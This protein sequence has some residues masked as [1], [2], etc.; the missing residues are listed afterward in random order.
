MNFSKYSGY[1]I[2]AGVALI[3]TIALFSPIEKWLNKKPSFAAIDQAFG[4]YIE[5]YTGGIIFSKSKI[6]IKL[7][8]PVADSSMIGKKIEKNLFSF[9]PNIEGSAYWIDENTIEFRPT[10]MLENEK[11]YK[12]A[13][14]LSDVCPVAEKKFSK[15]EFGFMVI[16]LDFDVKF[17]GLKTNN[18]DSYNLSGKL[19]STDFIE[20]EKIEKVLSVDKNTVKWNH[21]NNEHHF[22]ISDIKRNNEKQS[23]EIK[24]NGD[25]IDIDQEGKQIFNI[26]AKNSFEV[27]TII[28]KYTEQNSIHILFSDPL[29]KQQNLIGLIKLDN[30]DVKNYGI[31]DNELIIY[32]Q[33]NIEGS[34]KLF[35]NTGILNTKGNRFENNFETEIFFQS[36]LPEI[37]SEKNGLIF[38]E[39]SD[40]FLYAFQTIGL[41]SVNLIVF[42]I[43]KENVG[44]YFQSNSYQGSEDLKRFGKPKVFRTIDLRSIGLLQKNQWTRFAIDLKEITDIQKGNLYRIVVQF[45]HENIFKPCDENKNQLLSFFKSD[46]KQIL[47]DQFSDPNSNW[48]YLGNTRKYLGNYNWEEKDNPCNDAYYNQHSYF[49]SNNVISSDLGITVKQ[50]KP[51]NYF[52]AVSNLITSAGVSG[53]EI[54]IYDYQINL[55][56][57]VKTNSDGFAEI[58]LKKAPFMAVAK[59]N[60]DK[61]YIKLDN[62]S[63]LSTSNF[64]VAGNYIQNGLKGFIYGE[65]GVWRPGDTL[66]LSFILED[67]LKT[68]PKNHP[69]VFELKN[70]ENVTVQKLVSTQ[71]VN[72]VYIFKAKTNE[73]AVTGNYTAHVKVGGAQFE[74]TIRIE[75]IKPN[76]L[77]INLALGE[78]EKIYL[79]KD[80]K[81]Q[82]DVRYLNGANAGD[83]KVVYDVI[84]SKINTEFK[85]YSN[86]IFDDPAQY[87]ESQ[88]QTVF[89]GNLDGTGKANF[90]LVLNND[91]KYPSAL[92]MFLKGKVFEPGGDFSID[93]SSYTVFPYD[94][95]I[96]LKNPL[97]ENEYWLDVEKNQNFEFVT[98]NSRGQP[99]SLSNLELE[100]YKMDY[101]WWW[102]A[103]E[104]NLANYIDNEYYSM[105]HS[106]TLS[107]TNGKG[108]FKVQMPN[109]WGQ[110]YFRIKNPSTGQSCGKV[111]YFD[112]SEWAGRRANN[113][114]GGATMLSFNADKTNYNTGE[115]IVLTIPSAGEGHIL[116]TVENGST[117][118]NKQLIA[119]K[120]GSNI[121]KL[122]VEPEMAPN[123]FIYAALIQPYSASVNNIPIRQ[124]G[125]I[126]LGIENPETRLK[127]IITIPKEIKPDA[128]F[129]INIK[130]SK[131]KKMTYTI[132]VVDEGLLS[133]TRFKTPNPHAHFYAKEA[134]GIRT[135]DIY[136]E[137][138]GAYGGKL[139]KLLAIGG[140]AELNAKED[141][142]TLRFKPVVKFLGPFT[143]EA[144]KTANHTLSISN[145]VGEVRTMVIGANEGSYGA[146][147]AS[148]LIKNNLMLLATFPRTIAPSEEVKLPVNI[149]NL[150]KKSKKVRVSVKTNDLFSISNQKTQEI[151]IESQKD[152]LL[153]FDLKVN[154]K[155][156]AGKIEIIA[157][158]EGEKASENIDIYVLNPAD[159]QTKTYT[160]A[161]E[162]GKTEIINFETF[163]ISGSNSA[164]LEFNAFKSIDLNKRL[165]YLIDYPHG[166]L[167]QTLSAAFPQLYLNDIIDLNEYQMAEI[168]RNINAA[169]RKLNRFQQVNGSFSYW[170][171]SNYYNDWANN[172][173][174]HFLIEAQ[175]KGFNISETMLNNWLNY[176]S[177]KVNSFVDGKS[178]NSAQAYSLLTLAMAGNSNVGAM[179]R[180]KESSTLNHESKALLAWAYAIIGQIETGKKLLNDNVTGD[181]NQKFDPDNFSSYE[182]SFAFI[183]KALTV[184][185]IKSTALININSIID[186]I[187]TERFYNTHETAMMLMAVADFSKL[188]D[189]NNPP[190][191]EYVLNKSP[192]IEIGSISKGKN[193][194]L[195]LS[196][197]KNQLSVTNKGKS[198]LFAKVN[199]KGKP[200]HNNNEIKNDG[201]TLNVV[202]TDKKGKEID[203]SKLTQGTDFV[204]TVTLTSNRLYDYYEYRNLALNQIFPAGWEIIN[205]RLDGSEEGLNEDIPNY[206]DIRDSR[207]N[208]YFDMNYEYK[209]VF[210]VYL[211][212]AY[213]GRY[214]LPGIVL[215]NMYKTY[216]YASNQG[217]WVEV[218]K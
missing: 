26:P 201:I 4:D 215:E 73:E 171:S 86:Y 128:N 80:N 40:E 178:S 19:T 32:P 84:L 89:E 37:K 77:K 153:Y 187:N 97:E 15:F 13:F 47:E 46:E 75:T 131:G 161:V 130:E 99:I 202:Y 189:K 146:S 88:N 101:S 38:P 1:T 65:R 124:Y 3:V 66:F 121:I 2:L 36:I 193:E 49:I 35:L 191:A 96:G 166:C 160:I 210:K 70:P 197:T 114:S 211:N 155:E 57:K 92:K 127:P 14:K 106:Q 108:S 25:I 52:F 195:S 60:K 102:D 11:V 39:S 42:E 132:A 94:E 81:A 116:L 20:N 118:L 163:G 148:T 8:N 144:G 198:T 167:E 115:E 50:S 31:S 109:D 53:A 91:I 196:Q 5:A 51:K 112:Y 7:V 125:L 188:V 180:L 90:N 29:E 217:K 27:L 78:D 41:K 59:K 143:L 76:R 87:F 136:D 43:E 204:A 192:K 129:T 79:S 181:K 142:P 64:D 110:Y 103:D 158:S 139:Q 208:T 56:E 212:A 105:V 68:L 162:P 206:K 199:I 100:I 174:G 16:A 207:V 183:T 135:W 30:I 48:F 74:K 138:S 213:L 69:V 169:I 182:S 67:K 184:L 24:W 123:I 149:F 205:N 6:Q 165:A 140:D 185:N 170:P 58:N 157:Q 126:Y 45:G 120:A 17:D 71:S 159:Y 133:L 21:Q 176:Q 104:Y 61:T 168:Q 218:V 137:V 186:Y 9:S 95:Y 214:Y 83:L 200:I 117:I 72:G 119:A 111:L 179:N 173:A 12:A 98:L 209:K 44:F 62:A 23:I 152:K 28:N 93:N 82:L 175:K 18:Y 147:E 10:E 55:I 33:K 151:S 22:L 54:E 177:E 145:Y 34:K 141:N 134:L 154:A 122:K 156:G 113:K 107:S 194:N 164:V 203:P 216:P 85:G 172:Y 190:I 150:D 63:S